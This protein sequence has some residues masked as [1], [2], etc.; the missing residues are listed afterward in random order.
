MPRKSDLEKHELKELLKDVEASGFS[1]HDVSLPEIFEKKA[2]FYGDRKSEQRKLF[3]RR[4][5]ALKRNSIDNYRK[6][7][8]PVVALLWKTAYSQLVPV[9]EQSAS[10]TVCN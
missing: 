1:R 9:Q 6:S 8:E 7:S 5:Y 4:F 3:R 10:N 2:R